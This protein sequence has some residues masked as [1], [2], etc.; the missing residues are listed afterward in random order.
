LQALIALAI[1]YACGYVTG[2]LL[3]HPEHD[4][5]S[6]SLFLIR[7]IAGLLVT[8]LALLVSLQLTLPWFLGPAAVFILAVWMHRARGF[9]PP[10]PVFHL[11]WRGALA[12]LT[13]V[14]VLA[15]PLMSAVRMAPGQFPPVFMNVDIPYF[16]EKVHALVGT[17]IYPPES[18]SVLG[19]RRPY[20]F[21]VHAIA[22]LISRGSGLAPHHSVFLILV[23]L[24]TAGIL[25]AAVVLARAI[26]PALPHLVTIPLLLVSV[27]TLW[28]DYWLAVG[29]TLAK[30]VTSMSLNGVGDLIRNWQI[31]GLTSNIQNLAAH[32]LVLASLGGIA[33]APSA[34]WR[35]PVFLVGSAVIFKSPAGVALV[36]GFSLAQAYRATAARSFTPLIPALAA[37]TVF[38]VVYG[39][40]WILS[41]APSELRAVPSPLFYLV[42]LYE[43]GGVRWFA[44]DA[45]WLVLPVLVILP[46]ALG[47][48]EKRSGPLLMFA[49]A[50]FIVVNVLRLVDLRRG[51]GISSMNEDDWRQIIM[52]VPLLIHAF[53]LSFV[54]QRWTRLGRR[55]R[56]GFL[57]V[58]LM[59]AL[60]PV[61][62]AA[63]Y[64]YLV[65]MRPVENAYEFADN[66]A[67]AEALAVIPREGTVIVTNDLRYPADGFQRDNRQMQI[68][69][70]FGHQAFAVNYM[71]EAYPFSE[72][73]LRLQQLLK[74]ERWSPE[75][76]QAARTHRWT[77]L[78]V[79][80]DYAHPDPIPLE[81][82]FDSPFYS[83][84][85]FDR[86]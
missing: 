20:H 71:Y 21:G 86:E 44:L 54:G 28:Y 30:A 55:A 42:N 1:V 18:L 81:Q 61:L 65:L 40:F 25:A 68:P 49:V 77:H 19:G 74:A 29:P 56:A 51:F 11:D 59:T 64:T 60:P 76:E 50:P 79:R 63:R 38:G 66:H 16:V 85:R 36:A 52:P 41:S 73:R 7:V 15:P 53:V 2:S 37:A 8:A 69:A 70:I 26:S 12:G 13:A 3:I 23:P 32:F 10:R 33:N 57:L 83:V 17:D 39:A 67:I 31:W 62:A 9:A 45:L 4:R 22:A 75:I 5:A 35:L 24:L 58:V 46:A 47:D 84:F 27:P 43:H 14:I 72:E 6:L 82:I 48:P 34:G 78:L 80:K